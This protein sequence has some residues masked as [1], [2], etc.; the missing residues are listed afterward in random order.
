MTETTFIGPL[1]REVRVSADG[2][3]ITHRAGAWSGEYTRAQLTGWIVFYKRMAA[4]CPHPAY[5][6]DM[7]VLSAAQEAFGA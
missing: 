7:A 5:D 2:E 6:A 4:E 1:G 3:R